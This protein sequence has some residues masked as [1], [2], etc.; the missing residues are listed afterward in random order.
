MS[1]SEKFIENILFKRSFFKNEHTLL[2]TYVP[3]NLP[4]REAEIAQL[5]RT[6]KPVMDFDNTSGINVV[7][8]GPPG[9]GKTALVKNFGRAI[10][11]ISHKNRQPIYFKYYNCYSFRSKNS[12]LM[13]LLNRFGIF[14][15]G[16]G[17]E[18]LLTLLKH[19]LRK[20]D[21]R[22][23]LTLDEANLLGGKEVME[24][25]HGVIDDESEQSRVSI[26][27]ISRYTEYLSILSNVINDYINEKIILNT[28]SKSDLL[29]ILT[30]RVNLAFFSDTINSKLI[31]MVAN[32][33]SSTS[34][35]ARHG[36]NIIYQAGKLAEQQNEPKITAELIR[37]AKNNIYPEIDPKI[38]NELSN[39]KLFLLQALARILKLNLNKTAANFLELYDY[40]LVICEEYSL[41]LNKKI[42]HNSIDYT[43]NE[44]LEIIHSNIINVI[45]KFDNSTLIH[46]N[47]DNIIITLNDIPAE[48][49]DSRI[50]EILKNRFKIK[51]E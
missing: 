51:K 24:F 16:F 42:K 6:F 11:N 22:L 27:I 21:A 2:N 34:Q 48:I 31:E 41:L 13:D 50:T 8:I 45:P 46:E 28:Y 30:Y 35:N 37:Y 3:D 25:I 26:I 49:L 20:E 40:Y 36:I 32:I 10:V 4:Q 17:D 29:K 33:V 7:I 1:D 39:N 23:I 38:L 15:R 5:A 9:V 14:S 44:I 12:I 43:I 18:Q 19:R 47:L